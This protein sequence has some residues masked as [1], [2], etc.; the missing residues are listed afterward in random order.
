MHEIRA[1]VDRIV[2]GRYAVLLVEP[3]EREWVV[4]LERLPDEAREGV[5]LRIVCEGNQVIR[6]VI[7]A[8]LTQEA[9]DRIEA[10]LNLLRQRGRPTD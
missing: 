5:W 2:D 6:A 7:D 9:H 10:K 4:P 1:V 8:Q 3:S